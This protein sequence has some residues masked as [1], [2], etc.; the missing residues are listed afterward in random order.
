G[1]EHKVDENHDD[2]TTQLAETDDQ[3]FLNRPVSRWTKPR[4][5]IS[6]HDDDGH[7]GF[8]T[9]MF[10]VAKEYNIPIVSAMITDRPMQFPGDERP[11]RPQNYSYEQVVEMQESGLVEFVS[12]THTHPL[13]MDT[14]SRDVLDEEFRKSREFMKKWGFNH[15][16][17]VI[18]GGHINDK[19]IEEARQYYEYMTTFGGVNKVVEPPFSN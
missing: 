6:F 14:L 10:Q 4:P 7:L 12:H 17:V 13:N 11:Q 5:M 1:L 19:V 9:K 8:Y 18:P 2:V 16:V 3:S 15:R